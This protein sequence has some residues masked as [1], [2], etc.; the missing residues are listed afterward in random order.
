[1]NLGA[2]NVCFWEQT[3]NRVFPNGGG[4]SERPALSSD[5]RV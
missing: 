3:G 4:T 5:S 1:M 2:T